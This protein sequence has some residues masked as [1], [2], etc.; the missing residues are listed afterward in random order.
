MV[1]GGVAKHQPRWVPFSG[2]PQL[3]FFNPP[4]IRLIICVASREQWSGCI[5]SSGA[6]VPG[7]VGS[8]A[9]CTPIRFC[10]SDLRPGNG[11]VVAKSMMPRHGALGRRGY[12]TDRSWRLEV[13]GEA[14]CPIRGPARTGLGRGPG[15]AAAVRAAA[16][17]ASPSS[18]S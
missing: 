2:A 17:G 16:W 7:T 4:N 14:G 10:M 12:I 3:V 9:R 5:Q 6:T 13:T 1:M 18:P 8:R 11:G 15:I